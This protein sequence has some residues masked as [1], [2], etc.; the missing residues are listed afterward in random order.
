MSQ[1][2]KHD[3]KDYFDYKNNEFLWFKTQRSLV[4]PRTELP[5]MEGIKIMNQIIKEFSS[6]KTH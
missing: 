6:E 1:R 4:R 3:M 2:K 5:A